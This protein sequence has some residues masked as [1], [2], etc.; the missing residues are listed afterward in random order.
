MHF[1]HFQLVNC[2]IKF[3]YDSELILY[4]LCYITNTNHLGRSNTFSWDRVFV[5]IEIFSACLLLMSFD[6]VTD[7]VNYLF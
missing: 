7:V 5:E 4:H 6:D 2:I 3:K 1:V